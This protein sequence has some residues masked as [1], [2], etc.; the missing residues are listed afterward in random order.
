MV[1]QRCLNRI[2]TSIDGCALPLMMIVADPNQNQCEDYVPG[3]WCLNAHH[4]CRQWY[5]A[6][7]H[8]FDHSAK[9]H[10][11]NYWLSQVRTRKLFSSIHFEILTRSFKI[12]VLSPLSRLRCSSLSRSALRHLARRFWNHT[13]QRK[14]NRITF[15]S[16]SKIWKCN[17]SEYFAEISIHKLENYTLWLSLWGRE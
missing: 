1:S 10:K 12:G 2:V 15:H 13:Y 6:M 3:H 7:I 14:N 16:T 11:F 4:H 17:Y 9:N 5:P 8:D